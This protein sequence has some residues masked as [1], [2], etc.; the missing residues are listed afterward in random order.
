[1]ILIGCTTYDINRKANGDITVRVVTTRN[2]EQPQLH[3]ERIGQNAVFD[4]GASSTSNS[5]ENIIGGI[6]Q[7][8]MTGAIVPNPA[9]I[10]P[11]EPP[12]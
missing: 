9:V 1:M 6:L 3:Y 8:F 7:G 11:S 12:P 10:M 4:F 2:F 5:F